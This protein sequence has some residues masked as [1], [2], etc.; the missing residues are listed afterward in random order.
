MSLL[1]KRSIIKDDKTNIIT[2][3]SI[4]KEMKKKNKDVVNATIGMYYQDNGKLATFDIVN[5][6]I[7]KL[8]DDEKYAYSSSVGNVSFHEA[9]K[10]WVFQDS[11]DE[12]VNNNNVAVVASPGGSGAISNTFTNYLNINDK[13]LL[14]SFMWDNYKQFSYEN[15]T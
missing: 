13:V 9:I 15:I 11:Y 14:P 5:E 8:T 4:A 3:G 1:A 10:K 6:T 7:G 12:I 2:L